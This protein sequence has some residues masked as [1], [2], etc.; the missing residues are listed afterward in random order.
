MF[1]ART[2]PAAARPGQLLP[3]FALAVGILASGPL[4]L[5]LALFLASRRAIGAMTAPLPP[6]PLVATALAVLAWFA[7]VHA[8]GMFLGERSRSLPRAKSWVLQS[9]PWVTLLLVAYACSYPAARLVD[10]LVWGATIALAWLLPRLAA[11]PRSHRP[12]KHSPPAVAAPSVDERLLSQLTRVR[13]AA[14]QDAIRGTLVAELALGQRDA[15]LYIAFCPPFERLPSVE[16]EV[17]GS[18]AASVKLTQVL[19]HGAQL[20]LRLTRPAAQPTAVSVEV[21]AAEPAPG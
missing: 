13:T 18:T 4:L 10:W 11:T 21:F 3:R 20:E 15:T 9:V 12:L 7:V 5:A 1:A 14:G 6:L 17:D 16:A 2:E 8:A 19:H